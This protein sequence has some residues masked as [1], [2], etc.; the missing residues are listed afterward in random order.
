MSQPPPREQPTAADALRRIATTNPFYAIST[1]R[2]GAL[3]LFGNQDEAVETWL[4]MGSLAGYT[5]LLAV[6]A[7][8]LVRYLK[9]WEDTCTLLLLVVL[10]LAASVSFDH[11][12][13][14]DP[15]RGTVCY[16]LGLTLAIAISEVVRN[17]PSSAGGLS[18]ALLSHHCLVLSLPAVCPATAGHGRSPPRTVLMVAVWVFLG[19]SLDLAHAA[20]CP[21]RP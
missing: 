21:C 15:R 3:G 8:V 2:S 12:L 7:F 18:S 9:L 11:V 13:V 14:V 5:L 10:I 6:T 1:A 20:A 19:C 17:S 4:L 16:L